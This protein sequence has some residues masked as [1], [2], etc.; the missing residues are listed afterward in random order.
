V[1]WNSI[2]KP[3]GSGI[4]SGDKYVDLTNRIGGI[5]HDIR[6]DDWVT[7]LEQLGVQAAGLKREYFLSKI[8]VEDTIVVNVTLPDGT[9]EPFQ[10]RDWSY[11]SSRNSVTFDEYLPPPLSLVDI[12]YT[13][14]ASTFG[15]P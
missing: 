14:R 5:M 13:A 3:P 15:N 10:P 9:V 11:S 8:P 12:T 4:D 2:C 1:T 6:V 7:V